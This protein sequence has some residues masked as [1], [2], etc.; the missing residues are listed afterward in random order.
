MI[1]ALTC[2]SFIHKGIPVFVSVVLAVLVT[3]LLGGIVEKSTMSPIPG[4][5]VVTLIIITLGLSILIRG[6]G[7]IIWGAYP[8]GM[9]PFSSNEPI[10]I[11]GAVLIPQSMWVFAT[12]VVLLGLLY[13]F[14]EKKRYWEQQ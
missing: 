14:F 9:E 3:A 11:L 5:S 12:M 4:A 2:I 1:G 13:L 10:Q 7:Y 8:I 6:V